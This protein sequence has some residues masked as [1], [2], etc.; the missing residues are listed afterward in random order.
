MQWN[1][2]ERPNTSDKEFSKRMFIMWGFFIH[3]AVPIY[4]MVLCGG[5]CCG[6]LGIMLFVL[7][8]IEKGMMNTSEMNVITYRSH[9]N[10]GDG[11]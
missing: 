8:S 6:F 9:A 3:I 1:K 10:H 5:A 7:I 4:G 11:V 2:T